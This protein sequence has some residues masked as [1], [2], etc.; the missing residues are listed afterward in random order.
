M[1]TSIAFKTSLMI[2]FR[3]FL[4]ERRQR[5]LVTSITVFYCAISV[6]AFFLALVPCGTLS[7]LARKRVE[8]NTIGLGLC[9]TTYP[10]PLEIVYAGQ[11]EARSDFA[12]G[13]CGLWIFMRGAENDIYRIS[14]FRR[15]LLRRKPQA[16][17]PTR[18]RF[19]H[20][21]GCIGDGDRDYGGVC[22]VPDALV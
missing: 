4:L 21:H 16:E 12:D 20:Q 22:G 1:V 8:G 5:Y 13:V 14:A 19:G 10:G 11:D 7:H 17:L 3:Q 9:A 15:S 18:Y 6:L 2:F